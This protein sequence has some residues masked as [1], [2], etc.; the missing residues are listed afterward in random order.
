MTLTKNNIPTL[1]MG[2]KG[3]G[4]TT[5]ARQVADELKLNYNLI[6]MTRQ[7]TL[8]HLMGYL[9]VN[10]TY[11]TSPLR[12][13]FEGGGLFLIDEID[14]GD[15]NVL[16]TLNTIEN[17]YLSFP[18]TMVDAHPDFHLMAAANPKNQHEQ[19]T[20]RAKLDA[21]TLD[22]FD[23]VHVDRDENLEQSLVDFDTFRKMEI[24]RK[25]IR[26]QNILQTISMRDSIRYQKRK[27]LDLLQ[28]F[29]F[30]MVDGNELVIEKYHIAIQGMPKKISQSDCTNVDELIEIAM[31]QAGRTEV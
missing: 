14:A 24:L 25:I 8:G 9:S 5:L 12:K 2:E 3:S 18:D 30:N 1:L 16:L 11:I 15:P 10:G 28:D 20:G 4:K 27:E 17:G 29:V 22:R 26:E 7:T 31:I 23:K 6:A 13:S 21:A 19:Y